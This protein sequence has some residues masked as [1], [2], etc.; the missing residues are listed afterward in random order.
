MAVE[1]EPQATVFAFARKVPMFF[2]PAS[3]LML[4]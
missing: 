3:P 1:V 4:F 2:P